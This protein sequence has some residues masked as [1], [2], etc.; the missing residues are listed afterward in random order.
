MQTLLLPFLCD[1][2]IVAHLPFALE[3]LFWGVYYCSDWLVSIIVETY[4]VERISSFTLLVLRAR[5]SEEDNE[6]HVIA[7][8]IT[9]YYP[10]LLP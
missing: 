8:K 3:M 5:V 2:E 1:P 9:K 6:L 4:I 10:Q 7:V